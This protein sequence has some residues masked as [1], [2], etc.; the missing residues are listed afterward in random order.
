MKVLIDRSL[1]SIYFY[2]WKLTLVLYI[3]RTSDFQVNGEY[4]YGYPLWINIGWLSVELHSWKFISDS[5][6]DEIIETRVGI[7]NMVANVADKIRRKGN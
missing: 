3:R 6:L 2:L 4:G 5:K 1:R 7:L